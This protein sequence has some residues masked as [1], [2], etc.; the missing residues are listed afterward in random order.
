MK[1]LILIIL[2]I[3]TNIACGE[4]RIKEQSIEGG[5]KT[6]NYTKDYNTNEAGILRIQI[7]KGSPVVGWAAA[8][9]ESIQCIAIADV[10]SVD[11]E[12]LTT[13]EITSLP[14]IVCGGAKNTTVVVT[15]WRR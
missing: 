7:E 8:F 15:I 11:F 4:E 1:Q 9:P 12:K 10:G 5:T 13:G 2:V 14:F 3:L 6:E